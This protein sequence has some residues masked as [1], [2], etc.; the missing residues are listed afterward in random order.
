MKAFL[1]SKKKTERMVLELENGTKLEELKNEDLFQIQ[2]H[3]LL[4]CLEKATVCCQPYLINNNVVV[5]AAATNI[6]KIYLINY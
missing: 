4:N 2:H 5:V 1:S 3:H 6:R